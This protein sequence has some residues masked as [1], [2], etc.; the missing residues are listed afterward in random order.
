[1]SEKPLVVIIDEEARSNLDILNFRWFFQGRKQ[2]DQRYLIETPV[3]KKKEVQG[4]LIENPD[5]KDHA[6]EYVYLELTDVCN[7][8]CRHCGVKDSLD[9]TRNLVDDSVT[10]LTENFL[11]AFTGAIK[12]R[13]QIDRQTSSGRGHRNVFFGGGEPLISPLNFRRVKDM[14]DSLKSIN[15]SEAHTNIYVATNGVMLPL[16]QQEFQDFMGS[17]GKPYLI[18]SS[19]DAHVNQYARLATDSEHGKYVPN[20]CDPKEA[21]FE[22]AD[23]IQEYCQNLG[24]GFVVNLV[25]SRYGELRKNIIKSAHED[26]KIFSTTADGNRIPCSQGQELSVRANGNV[27]PHCYDIFNG[28][29]KLGVMGLLIE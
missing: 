22:K 17:I 9:F 11:R 29:N 2:N 25:E 5:L 20:W 3:G 10:Y 24:V 12:R 27:Y 18:L 8:N 1:M 16:D 6:Q 23:L 21:L 15:P 28:H 26:L 4:T 19:S 7:F 13:Y 14:F